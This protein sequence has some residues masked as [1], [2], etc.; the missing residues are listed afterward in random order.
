M[1]LRCFYTVINLLVLTSALSLHRRDNPSVLNF[2]ETTELAL[3]IIASYAGSFSKSSKSCIADILR[4]N[5]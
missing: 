3:T 1:L 5:T 2:N 4:S